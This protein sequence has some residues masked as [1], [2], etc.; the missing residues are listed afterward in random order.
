MAFFLIFSM[1]LG[2]PD[3]LQIF[4]QLYPVELLGLLTGMGLL[5]TVAL[6]ISKSSQT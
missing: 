1:V 6:D 3:Q 4:S 2:L 5:Q